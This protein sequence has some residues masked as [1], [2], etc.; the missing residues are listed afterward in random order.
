MRHSRYTQRA[1]QWIPGA[2]D[3]DPGLFMICLVK[4]VLTLENSSVFYLSTGPGIRSR[5]I[6][7]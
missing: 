2:F 5:V 1:L 4:V 3:F 6:V 7:P